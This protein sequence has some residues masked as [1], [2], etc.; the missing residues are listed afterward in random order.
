MWVLP[1]IRN[2][3]KSQFLAWPLE[4]AVAAIELIL[5]WLLGLG[6]YISSYSGRFYCRQMKARGRKG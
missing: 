5:R 2:L 3:W 1:E 6:G 4:L